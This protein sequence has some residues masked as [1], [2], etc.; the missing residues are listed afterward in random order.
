MKKKRKQRLLKSSVI[1]SESSHLMPPLADFSF[2]FVPHLHSA[3]TKRRPLVADSSGGALEHVLLSRC[4]L[5]RNER[6]R[7]RSGRGFDA[8]LRLNT[9]THCGIT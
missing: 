1:T 5:Q 7:Y 2:F 3:C 9:R 6:F 8:I 4:F